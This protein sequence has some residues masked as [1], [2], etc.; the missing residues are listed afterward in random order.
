MQVLSQVFNGSTNSCSIVFCCFVPQ[1]FNGSFCL[2][3]FCSMHFLAQIFQHFLCAVSEFVS[4]NACFY[5]FLSL[6]VFC[7]TLLGIFP[8]GIYVIITKSPRSGNRS[9]LFFLSAP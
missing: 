5:Q 9:L 4:F 7:G 1:L 2:C 6:L 3:P 8:Y